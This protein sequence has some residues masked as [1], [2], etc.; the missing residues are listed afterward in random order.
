MKFRI[1]AVALALVLCIGVL[2]ACGN[3]EGENKEVVTGS[4]YTG[5]GETLDLPHIDIPEEHSTDDEG[6]SAMDKFYEEQYAGMTPEE[7][8]Q[9][10]QDLKDLGMT[11]EE[12]YSLMFYGGGD[13]GMTTAGTTEPETPATSK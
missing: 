4:K 5:T 8:A 1:I 12:F 9:F 6:K 13:G 7:I 3:D 2:C 11:K 10:E